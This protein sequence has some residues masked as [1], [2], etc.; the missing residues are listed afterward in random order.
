M[1]EP[2]FNN[3]S[4]SQIVHSFDQACKLLQA[5]PPGPAAL[6]AVDAFYFSQISG[7][8]GKQDMTP[9]EQL[10][11]AS[12]DQELE[13]AANRGR[14]VLFLKD[15]QPVFIYHAIMDTDGKG[16][17]VYLDLRDWD[18]MRRSGLDMLTD[19]YHE[20][21]RFLSAAAF[22]LMQGFDHAET[23]KRVLDSIKN[24][25]RQHAL[26]EEDIVKMERLIE[27]AAEDKTISERLVTLHGLPPRMREQLAGATVTSP[28]C[29]FIG[30]AQRFMEDNPDP[31]TIGSFGMLPPGFKGFD[32]DADASSAK[33]FS[34][35]KRVLTPYWNAGQVT[36]F[37]I[38]KIYHEQNKTG[39]VFEG[40]YR[41][42]AKL[43]E[44]FNLTVY[45]LEKHTGHISPPYPQL[46]S[47]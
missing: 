28:F 10:C 36:N 12:T 8:S 21:N 25:L 23:R 2:V 26:G 44:V 17:D 37:G 11:A 33:A 24:K 13:A 22:D 45:N 7:F 43:S 18:A 40:T 39:L 29:L 4:K 27:Q 46:P 20:Q 41:A 1:R 19:A 42:A 34:E 6:K 35:A 30:K 47:P 38:G 31:N 14:G 9:Y 3:I 15:Y 16:K 5:H 32:Y